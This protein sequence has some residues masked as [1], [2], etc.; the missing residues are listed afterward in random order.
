MV[1]NVKNDSLSWTPRSRTPEGMGYLAEVDAGELDRHM[2]DRNAAEAV[3]AGKTLKPRA[4][5][6]VTLSG[7]GSLKSMKRRRPC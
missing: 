6:Y 2:Y 1:Q 4:R 3:A 5:A 7:M